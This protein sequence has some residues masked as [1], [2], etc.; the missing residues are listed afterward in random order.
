MHQSY[1]YEL[2]VN[3]KARTLLRKHAG[4]A[5]FVYNWGLAQRM[6]EYEVTGKSSNAIEQ[7]RQLNRLKKT[8]YPWMY[9]V[10]KCAPQEALRDLDRAMGNFF[11]GRQSKK[12]VGYPKFKKKGV[13]ESF[14]LTGSIHVSEK[15]I[16]LP[17]I[18]TVRTTEKTRIRGRILSVTVSEEADRWTIS[19]HV[20]RHGK[21]Q[22]PMEDSPVGVDMG[23][24]T[25]AVCSDGR[26]VDSPRPLQRLLHILKR[27]SRQHFRKKKGSCNRKKSRLCLARLHRRIRN[28]RK[29]FLHKVSTRLAKTKSEIVVEDLHVRG[30]LRNRSLS[31][32]IQD[33]GWGEF[34]RML[35]YKTEWY[36]S[37]FMKA[38]RF[39]PSTRMC[40]WCGGVNPRMDLSER[41]FGCGMCGLEI[42]R[43]ENA[44]LNLYDLSTGS[45]PGDDACGDIYGGGT[46]DVR[47]TSYVSLKQEADAECP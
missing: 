43:D 7:H 15:E 47:S 2:K 14:R 18:S 40:S 29:D 4:T 22:K 21:E 16:C 8:E 30:M 35:G 13:H 11:R 38:P 1:R 32:Q 46:H 3:N 23:V 12:R 44:A 39:Y 19:V 17:R 25:F 45:S 41:E 24:S 31:R 36:G 9:E 34:I 26:R 10:S 37:R 42:D 5:R 33:Q 20:E 28:Q 6:T 27:R